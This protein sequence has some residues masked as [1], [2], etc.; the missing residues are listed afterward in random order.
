M[1]SENAIRRQIAVLEAWLRGQGID[2]KE[3]KA[4]L[5]PDSRERI[6]WHYGYL[7]GLQDA[8][9]ALNKAKSLPLH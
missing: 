6:Y 7:M 9:N 1:Y 8:V 5:D 2:V 3:E 4:H